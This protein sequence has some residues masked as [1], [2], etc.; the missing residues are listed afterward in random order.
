MAA[1]SGPQ[2]H[3]RTAG[4]ARSAAAWRRLAGVAVPLCLCAPVPAVSQCP[5]GTPPPCAHLAAAGRA[6]ARNSVAVLPFDNVRLDSAFAYL[7]DGL[8]SEIA[9]SLAVVPRLEV[10]S[11]GVVRGLQRRTGGDP[12]LLGRRLGVRYVVEGDFQRSGERLRVS[13]RL[14]T[15]SDGTQRWSRAYTRIA[16]DLLAVQDDVAREVTI[17]IA[18]QLL[19]HE[20]S[21]LAAR[22]TRDP[23]A[24]DHYLRGNYHL[25]RRTQEGVDR[26]IE[27]YS[28]A[29]RIDPSFARAE[30]GV[31]L[32]YALYADWGWPSPLPLD[33]LVARGLAAAGRAI[34]RDSTDSDGW[35]AR[36]YLRSIQT[37]RDYSLVL[38]DLERSV[39]L[40]PRNAEALHQYASKMQELNDQERAIALERRALEADPDRPVSQMTIGKAYWEM[41]R[42]EEAR[43]AFDSSLALDPAFYAANV[44]RGQLELAQGHLAAAWRDADAAMRTALPGDA[45]RVTLRIACLAAQGDTAA[46][47]RA[48]DEVAAPYDTAASIS[49]QQVAALAYA[50][51]RLGRVD[52]ALRWLARARPLGAILWADLLLPSYDPLRHDPRFRRFVDSIR[53]IRS[54]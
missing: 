31:A 52:D 16:T 10:R 35:M 46:A 21:L 8:A 7:A 28:L 29:T 38:P 26:A 24:W 48:L 15:V 50:A 41:R 27:E 19:P 22:V 23:E 20:R 54:R 51:G 49:M 33:T 36:G 45:W 47:S 30:A 9:T 34:A 39:S 1:G 18:G 11:P 43:R 32:G 13:V 42:L 4:R 44:Y 3:G 14:V 17:S 12:L 6:A 53:P 5:D 37:A 40:D 2:A 25:A